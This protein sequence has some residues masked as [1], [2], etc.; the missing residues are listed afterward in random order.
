MPPL[1]LLTSSSLLISHA[2][3]IVLIVALSSSTTH[4]L[5]VIHADSVECCS[6][7]LFGLEIREPKIYTTLPVNHIRIILVRILI[8]L[9]EQNTLWLVLLCASKIAM[10][11]VE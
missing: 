8:Y 5:L 7:P 3:K 9:L 2:N 1:I 10:L 11:C 6:H 4:I